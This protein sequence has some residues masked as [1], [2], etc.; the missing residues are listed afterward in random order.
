MKVHWPESTQVK[1]TP[2]K[3]VG[4][5]STPD[6]RVPPGLISANCHVTATWA[7]DFGHPS[8][9]PYF[10]QEGSGVSRCC[11]SQGLEEE[12]QHTVQNWVWFANSL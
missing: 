2:G 8:V 6:K 9:V 1:E 10:P 4:S 11:L 7:R 5:D 3:D 12:T